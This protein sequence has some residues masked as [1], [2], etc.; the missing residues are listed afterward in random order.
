MWRRI[1]KP[2][3]LSISV[4]LVN[5]N[6]H[7]LKT[8]QEREGGYNLALADLGGGGDGGYNPPFKIFL[9]NPPFEKFPD[10]RLPCESLVDD[11]RAFDHLPQ[12]L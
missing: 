1:Q 7:F 3:C 4:Q 9:L 11:S 2:I 5:I 8:G 6:K 10:P 12:P